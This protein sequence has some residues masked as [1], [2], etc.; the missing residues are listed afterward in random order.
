MQN[1]S[2]CPN[3]LGNKKVMG[4]SSPDRVRHDPGGWKAVPCPLCRGTGRVSAEEAARL[5]S[6][7]AA[8][9]GTPAALQDA[10]EETGSEP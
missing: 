3:C 2:L 8:E 6:T 9:Q 10:E 4:F 5:A 7:E 1:A